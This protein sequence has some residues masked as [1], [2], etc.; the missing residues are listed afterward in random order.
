MVD[1]IYSLMVDHDACLTYS[2]SAKRRYG[3]REELQEGICTLCI[4][5]RVT[6]EGCEQAQNEGHGK[7][8][9]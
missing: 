1:L 7:W 2:L 5:N 8:C 4:P 9:P 6:V 3:P